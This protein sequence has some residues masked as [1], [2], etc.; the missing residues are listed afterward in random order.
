MKLCKDWQLTKEAR[1]PLW[2]PTEYKNTH[3]YMLSGKTWKE[4]TQSNVALLPDALQTAPNYFFYMHHPPI[5]HS[6]CPLAVVDTRWVLP[7]LSPW[8]LPT[9]WPCYWGRIFNALQRKSGSIS[10]EALSSKLCLCPRHET[11]TGILTF[12]CTL[13]QLKLKTS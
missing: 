6:L 1:L 9:P 12:P 10:L 4:R 13:L 8:V 5:M 3:L 2:D 11:L 7:V